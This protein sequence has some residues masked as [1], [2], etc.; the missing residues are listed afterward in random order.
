MDAMTCPYSDDSGESRKLKFSLPAGVVNVIAPRP[1]A[2]MYIVPLSTVNVKLCGY[3]TLVATSSVALKSAINSASLKFSA[4]KLKLTVNGKTPSNGGE[5]IISA[6]LNGIDSSPLILTVSDYYTIHS[7]EDLENIL[8]SMGENET[9]IK[10]KG[11]NFFSDSFTYK[12]L[13]KELEKYGKD[14]SVDLSEAGNIV[15][16]ECNFSGNNSI[17]ELI[18][19]DSLTEIDTGLFYGY[20][21]LEKVILPE[22]LKV[23]GESAFAHSTIKEITLPESL[24][25]IGACAFY[26]CHNLQEVAI[27]GKVTSIGNVAFS[28][29]GLQK[30]TFYGNANNC[31]IG[32]SVFPLDIPIYVYNPENIPSGSPWKNYSLQRL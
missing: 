17:K 24:E 14:F 26:E 11:D 18:L 1:T 10:I 22:N 28:G 19:P 25:K 27:P 8:N 5:I 15:F 13:E 2:P 6:N 30:I 4:D 20:R 3:M 16:G 21:E 29:K 9:D 12:D 7:Q 32:T 31:S 23:I